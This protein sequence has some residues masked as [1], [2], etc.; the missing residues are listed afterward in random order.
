M[1]LPDRETLIEEA[2]LFMLCISVLGATFLTGLIIG[3]EAIASGQPTFPPTYLPGFAWEG[4]A[5]QKF[6]TIYSATTSALWVCAIGTVAW[7]GA[8]AIRDREAADHSEA[9][10]TDAD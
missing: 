2:G 7:A 5:T 6:V 9:A 8:A 1:E 3:A 4:Q 10:A